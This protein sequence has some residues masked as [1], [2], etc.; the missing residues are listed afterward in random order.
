MGQIKRAGSHVRK[1]LAIA[2]D[3]AEWRVMGP[4]VDAGLLPNIAA[5]RDRSAFVRLDNSR[6]LRTEFLWT[7]FAT[8]RPAEESGFWGVANF[9]PGDYDG[10]LKAERNLKPWWAL[11]P[12]FSSVTI[13]IP[14]RGVITD[15]GV[16]GPQVVGWG[17][18]APGFDRTSLPEGLLREVDSR[19]G[20]HPAFDRECDPLWYSPA[21]LRNVTDALVEG[22]ALRS[23]VFEYLLDQTPEWDFALS[24]WSEA[25][26]GGHVM[27]HG[28]DPS[29]PAF[30]TP[31][32]ELAGEQMLRIH[33]ALDQAVGRAIANA[34]ECD[35]CVFSLHGMKPNCSDIQTSVLLP[36]LLHRLHFKKAALRMP[37]GEE[38]RASG[39]PVVVPEENMQWIDFVARHF[40]DSVSRRA[41]NFVKRALPMSLLTAAR[42]AT[43]R[44]SHKP[45]DLVG[46]IPPESPFSAAKEG[47]GKSEPTYMPLWW[48]RHRWPSM[49]YFAIPSFT[50]GLVRINLRGRERDGI[51][52][53]ED[54]QRTC[55]E[56]IA[57][58][59]SATSP[60]TGK[61]IVAEF[62]MMRAE[63]PFDPAGAPADILF[64]W[65]DTTQALDHPTAG[66][67]GPVPYQRAGEHDGTGF[68]LFNGD[69]IAP[70]DLG[71]RPGLDLAATI[72]TMLGRDPV[73]PS[74]G[75]SIL[76]MQ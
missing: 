58:V 60:L 26:S 20:P 63:D 3:S 7:E 66:L 42:R 29:H 5:L 76:D 70:G 56:V 23:E 13:D 24:V 38:W 51:V 47:K 9:E 61:S 8:G 21:Y 40:A 74:A 73:N 1:V 17:A 22:A 48:Y 41:M 15:E 67:I 36:E 75:V 16:Y 46:D 19:F 59:R 43:G 45:G 65:S 30:A 27:W 6:E 32:A 49:R 53:I 37:G 31:T 28:A 10:R 62:F 14:D 34:G 25:H 50:E 57:E 69:G 64:R 2:L 18:H 44:T 39:M 4:L 55:E 71:T 11:G 68:A 54:Y 33:V 12:S 35:V 52:D 72:Q